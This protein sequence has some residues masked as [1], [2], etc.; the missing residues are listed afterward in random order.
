MLQTTLI[1][2]LAKRVSHRSSRLV[3]PISRVS[4]STEVEDFSTCDLHVVESPFPPISSNNTTPLTE[5]VS[6][7]WMKPNGI[8]RN[9]VAIVD[10]HTSQTRTYKEYHTAMG[11]IAA[12]LKHELGITEDSTVALYS[13]N[14]V[15]YVPIC[16]AVALC[17]AKITPV[18]P[19]FTVKELTTILDRSES[20]VLITHWSIKDVALEAAKL[21]KAVKHIV[22][23]PEDDGLPVPEGTISLSSLKEHDQPIF[24]TA[25]I[26]EKDLVNNPVLLPYSSGTTGLPKGVCLSH[27]N[28]IANLMQLEAIESI[29]FPSNHRLISPLPF[30]HIYGYLVSALYCAWQGQEIITMSGRFDLE[31]F[32]KLVQ[33]YQPHRA[34]LVPPILVGLAKHPI[35]DNYDLSSLSMIVSAAAPLS[36]ETEDLVKTRIGSDIKQGWGMSELSPI[37]TYASDYNTVT[38]SVGQLV[39][40]TYGKIMDPTTNMSLGPNEEGELMIKG[41]QVMIGYL[42]E[43]DKTA[44]CLQSGWL[45]TG[46][47]ATYD[48]EGF[49][50]I[51][52]RIKELIKVRGYQVAPAELESLLLSHPNV[53][54]AAVIP[55]DNEESGQLPRA[56]ITLKSDEES[57]LVQEEDI[58]EWVKALVAPYKRLEGGVEFIDQVPKSASGKILRRL[59][60]D[61][62]KADMS[63]Q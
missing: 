52:D 57:L 21:S 48:K 26:A 55:I 54:D 7:D 42:N 34:H 25:N 32:C 20:K 58:K 60:V 46:D 14:H 47:I 40:S 9:K 10:G 22:T 35:V 53:A 18:N 8:L 15:D 37:G 4:F 38:G 23:I 13:P 49:F 50:F 39:S 43:P 63:Q 61:R 5:F 11:N 51:T 1:R 29:S 56:Y 3:L 27:S 19:L 28:L 12:N 59:L 44:E 6:A 30:F 33:K 31:L 36:K 41:P 62:V 2:S 16:L 24:E 45:R 17:G